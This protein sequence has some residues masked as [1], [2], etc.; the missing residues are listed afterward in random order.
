MW[1]AI[2][3]IIAWHFRCF[4]QSLQMHT[5]EL[6]RS[7]YGLLPNLAI[8]TFKSSPIGYMQ[9]LQLKHR[10]EIPQSFRFSR[11]FNFHNI[12]YRPTTERRSGLLGCDFMQCCDKTPTFRRTLLPPSSVHV[13]QKMEPTTSSET[14]VPYHN[15]TWRHDP[16][17]IN[18]NFHRR[19]NFSNLKT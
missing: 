4:C 7:H 9:P 2:V 13:V 17:D 18:M 3:L 1:S 6:S 8:S 12:C 5:D 11:C 19:K 15:T 16:E 10:R 14:S